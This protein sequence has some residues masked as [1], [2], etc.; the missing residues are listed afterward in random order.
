MKR[1]IIESLVDEMVKDAFY[2]L[3]SD[4]TDDEKL[5]TCLK[6]GI[7]GSSI[8]TSIVEDVL[9]KAVCSLNEVSEYKMQNKVYS[10]PANPNSE[11][12]EN[13]NY[14]VWQTPKPIR[15]LKMEASNLSLSPDPSQIIRD[16][17]SQEL[18]FQPNNVHIVCDICCQ[19]EPSQVFL[20]E[21]DLKTHTLKMHINPL[22]IS[23]S[24]LSDIG[25]MSEIEKA[26]ETKLTAIDLEKL[27]ND[28][29]N[30]SEITEKNSN[31]QESNTSSV[32]FFWF[33]STFAFYSSMPSI[34][35]PY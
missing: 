10:E 3:G 21:T 12:I 27:Q 32:N 18:N 31:E 13:R 23:P 25:G 5:K 30:R 1:K 19:N 15:S 11:G 29:T 35:C 22:F 14:Y 33:R 28:T 4:K 17:K 8:A 16:E 26:H 24:D 20:S 7:D 34:H 2:S 6:R 9:D